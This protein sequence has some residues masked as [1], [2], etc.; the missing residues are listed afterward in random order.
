MRRIASFVLAALTCAFSYAQ[1]YDSVEGMLTGSQSGVSVS[2]DSGTPI[3]SSHINI[4]GV[5]S[6]KGLSSPL[7]IVD[8]AVLNPLDYDTGNPFYRYGYMTHSLPQSSL[9][10]LS[11]NDIKEIKVVK[12]LSLLTEYGS[13]GADGVVVITTRLHEKPYDPDDKKDFGFRWRS[14]VDFI[15]GA[16]NHFVNISGRRNK[17]LY[18]VSGSWKGLQ[19]H[20]SD[21]GTGGFRF[22][23]S[24]PTNNI[25]HW[26]M[27]ASASIGNYGGLI[28]EIAVSADSD[29]SSTEYRTTDAFFMNVKVSENMN[30]RADFG[31]DYRLKRRYIWYGKGTSIGDMENGAASI[32]SMMA[33]RSNASLKID[34][35]KY[36]N[37]HR[38]GAV[39]QGD[40]M[41][42]GNDGSVMNGFDFFNHSLKAHGIN[43]A[44]G[45]IKL[46]REDWQLF[47]CG[48]FLKADYDYRKIVGADLMIRLDSTPSFDLGKVCLYPAAN[49]FADIRQ[50]LFPS[51]KSF[52]TFRITA[53]YGQG[54]SEQY[55]PYVR[56][57]EYMLSSDYKASADDEYQGFYRSL[58]RHV[59]SEFNVGASFGFLSDRICLDVKYY[60]KNTSEFFTIICNGEEFDTNGYWRYGDDYPVLEE[61]SSI[62]NAGVELDLSA[63]IIDRRNVNWSVSF[64]MAY[65]VN[66]VLSVHNT[67]RY[68]DTA[69]GVWIY[70]DVPGYSANAIVGYDHDESGYVDHTGDGKITEADMVVLGTSMPV[71]NASLGT[72]LRVGRFTLDAMA[73]GWFGNSYVDVSEFLKE[74]PSAR[75]TRDFLRSGSDILPG[76]ISLSY[77]VPL[78][79]MSSKMGLKV[80]VAAANSLPVHGY[81]PFKPI[82]TVVLGVGIDF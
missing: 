64:N 66:K 41:Y 17:N 4:R 50:M 44:S 49:V 62:R 36:F 8:G 63:D 6:I 43:L 58:S 60:L 71:L 20:S 25:F 27:N 56:I 65:N 35:Y 76:R 1:T 53:G 55:V 31:F 73:T 59:S 51:S 78:G 82:R 80:N 2:S 14:E 47:T 30:I 77:D 12:D 33:L 74:G 38:I 19:S 42:S 81:S 29:D 3:S 57:P 67:D 37:D 68:T 52:S 9:L 61:K 79:K 24:A 54:G 7:F 46:H 75:M 18:Y 21:G 72:S 34:Y 40:L 39:L 45:V 16:H 10:S 5:N 69:S 32:G 26:G 28:P 22:N 23:I 15:Q 11:V 13:K 70:S 48:G